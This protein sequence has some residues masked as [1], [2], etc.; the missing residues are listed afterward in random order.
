MVIQTG[1][2][3]IAACSSWSRWERSQF[4]GAAGRHDAD[5]EGSCQ[6]SGKWIDCSCMMPS[7]RCRRTPLPAFVHIASRMV[8]GDP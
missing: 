4:S 2:A 8:R 6:V 1:R 7:P 5:L 3:C